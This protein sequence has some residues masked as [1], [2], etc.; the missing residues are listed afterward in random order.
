MN[1]LLLST[2]P[3]AVP[4]FLDQCKGQLTLPLRLGY[5]SDAAEDMPFAAVERAGVEAFGYEI[6]EIRVRETDAEAFAGVL[7]SFDAVYVASGETFVLLEALRS[8]GTG[9]VLADRVRAG[10]PYIGCS[11]GSIIAGPSVTPA[12]LMDDRDSAPGLRSDDGLNLI[13]NVVIPHADGKLPP[14]P[15]ELIE[16]IV[17]TYGDSYPL[18][19][20]CDD[21]ALRV[22]TN[23][24]EVVTSL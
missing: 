5:I 6:V 4:G 9:D 17:T 3:G 7:D 11:A 12:E 1:L 20:L 15:P 21:Q 24:S 23:G 14:Y 13:D 22:T 16:R 2:N 8:N 10:L 18:L 19:T